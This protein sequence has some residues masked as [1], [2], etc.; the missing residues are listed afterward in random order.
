[1]NDF[2]NRHPGGV[3]IVMQNA[4]KDAS[5]EWNGI[6]APDTI[7]KIAPEVRIGHIK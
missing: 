5:K 6:H 2:I 7:A 3:E 4:G 1:M